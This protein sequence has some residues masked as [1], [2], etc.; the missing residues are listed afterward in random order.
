MCRHL[1]CVV[2]L[3]GCNGVHAALLEMSQVK[4]GVVP[5]QLAISCKKLDLGAA[6][7]QQDGN[8]PLVASFG[9]KHLQPQM[10]VDVD[11][12]K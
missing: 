2:S 8:F 9:R 5:E 7:L 10:I 6:S 11:L 1:P 3:E 4:V 12:R